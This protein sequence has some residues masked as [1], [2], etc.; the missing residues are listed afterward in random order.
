MGEE[1]EVGEKGASRRVFGVRG[2]SRRPASRLPGPTVD[3]L[4]FVPEVERSCGVRRAQ[5]PTS[6]GISRWV[7][8]YFKTVEGT[9]FPAQ[10]AYLDL[11]ASLFIDAMGVKSRSFERNIAS[12]GAVGAA[13]AT[14]LVAGR[15]AKVT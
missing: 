2:G 7:K 4:T 10:D 3:D 14:A 1:V 11:F 8:D 9:V 12:P 15:P 13:P 5:A 6:Q